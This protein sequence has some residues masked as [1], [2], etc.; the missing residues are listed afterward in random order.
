MLI[1][2]KDL[3]LTN[4]LI[5]RKIVLP[6]GAYKS[7]FIWPTDI[8][9]SP[10]WARVPITQAYDSSSDSALTSALV[11][12]ET[13]KWR[14]SYNIPA[15]G[16]RTVAVRIGSVSAPGAILT[17]APTREPFTPVAQQSFDSTNGIDGT[18]TDL[19]DDT[20]TAPAGSVIR[21]R[22]AI[23][24]TPG[25]A[26]WLRLALTNGDTVNISSVYLMV[27]QLSANGP[28][29]CWV[30]IGASLENSGQ[31]SIDLESAFVSAFPTR[32]PVIFNYS[33]GG[34]SSD[35]VDDWPPAINAAWGNYFSYV[36]IG[37]VLGND[38]T[39]AQPISDDTTLSLSSMRARYE[40]ILNAFPGK[41]VFPC[42]TTYRAYSGVTPTSPQNGSLPYNV[43]VGDPAILANV[44]GAYDANLNIPRVDMYSSAQFNR[45]M[46]ADEV[47]FA[48]YVWA[49]NEWA[50][51]T[52]SRVYNGAWPVSFAER[53]VSLAEGSTPTVTKT[54]AQYGIDTLPFSSAK[55]ALQ[56]RVTAIGTITPITI[57]GSKIAAWWTADDAASITNVSGFI[58]SWADQV[59][60][61]ALTAGVGLR[62]AYSATSFNGSPAAD[63]DGTDDTLVMSAG[64]PTL[65]ADTSP[66]E[67]WLVVSQDQLVAVTTAAVIAGYGT[68]G[69]TVSRTVNRNVVG[70][71]NRAGARTGTGAG[72][73]TDD[74]I[75][76]DFTG[77]HVVRV[78]FGATTTTVYVDNDAGTSYAAVPST[79]PNTRIRL[80]AAMGGTS[81]YF[82]GLVRDFLITNALLSTDEA[83][84]MW[85]TWGLPKRNV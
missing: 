51:T 82:L 76:T 10:G 2:W 72:S 56:A 62:P 58:S 78:V 1:S 67:I 73:S 6:N 77:R 27:H 9:P 3:K 69:N 50:R 42:R 53:L 20:V 71:V 57:A 34:A 12:S 74:N 18:W 26:R 30:M 65:P 23:P 75:L 25:A 36:L 63:F 29:D 28:N 66:S 54:E 61:A 45:A 84:S 24:V 14:G 64:L 17:Y 37:N 21:R 16:T 70:G 41:Y 43:Q 39:A 85:A 44:S 31:R 15:S 33:I 5:S 55:S 83:A 11:G 47:H 79:G 52:G 4:S 68:T 8:S 49:R 32:D 35:I 22:Q 13:T 80:G 46:L 7:G 19:P 38:I 81:N 60:G 59:S 48:N 40:T